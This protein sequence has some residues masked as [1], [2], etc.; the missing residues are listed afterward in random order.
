MVR[1]EDSNC[2]GSVFDIMA[3]DLIG[4]VKT[5]ITL[6]VILNDPPANA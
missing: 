2:M 4:P 5:I 1:V 3:C 6:F